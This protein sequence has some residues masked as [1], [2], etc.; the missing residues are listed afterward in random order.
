MKN[1]TQ[2][3]L[4]AQYELRYELEERID[5]VLTGMADNEN[6]KKVNDL[7]DRLESLNIEIATLEKALLS[8]HT[9]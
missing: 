3:I 5:W 1:I 4:N 6:T 7:M 9:Q 8:S 2:L